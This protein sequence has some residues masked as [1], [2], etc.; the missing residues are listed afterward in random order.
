M[1]IKEMK[2]QII[3]NLQKVKLLVNDVQTEE[4]LKGAL[5]ILVDGIQEDID[6]LE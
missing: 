2:V 4:Q 6:S 3:S 5:Q 1:S